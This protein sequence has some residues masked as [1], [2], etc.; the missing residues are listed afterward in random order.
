MG[1]DRERTRGDEVADASHSG[2]L[3]PE[4]RWG[5]GLGDAGARGELWPSDPEHLSSC[6]LVPIAKQ[7]QDPEGNGDK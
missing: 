7:V 5:Q 3:P 1:K 4:G 6:P 2:E